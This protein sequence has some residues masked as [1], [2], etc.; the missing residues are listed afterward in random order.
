MKKFLVLLLVD[1]LAYVCAALGAGLTWLI[2]DELT[3]VVTLS[4]TL[5]FVIMIVEV[6]PIYR[7]LKEEFGL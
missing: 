3:G 1:L 2:W 5:L 7:Q 4:W 6:G